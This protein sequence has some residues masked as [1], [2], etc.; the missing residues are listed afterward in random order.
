[1]FDDVDFSS[2]AAEDI[3]CLLS[4]DKLRSPAA[5]YSDAFSDQRES[6]RVREDQWGCYQSR[7]RV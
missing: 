6:H 5:R 1:M 3:I 4:I 7:I 2:W